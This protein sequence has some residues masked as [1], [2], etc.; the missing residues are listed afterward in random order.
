VVVECT[1]EWRA[2]VLVYLAVHE[3]GTERWCANSLSERQSFPAPTSAPC[4]F[5]CSYPASHPSHN[6][7]SLRPHREPR[8]GAELTISIDRIPSNGPVRHSR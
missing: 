4:H 7:T 6:L 2:Y 1:G 3:K 8:I 5:I